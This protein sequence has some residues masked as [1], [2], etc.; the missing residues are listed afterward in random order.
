MKESGYRSI[1]LSKQNGLWDFMD[2][3]D[4]LIVPSDLQDALFNRKNAS[5]FFHSINA[6]SKRF[7]LRYVK[8]AKTEKT[9][10]KRI[11]QIADLSA[12]GEKLKGS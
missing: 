2:D 7:V 12:N 6:S 9:R 11:E 3:V 5:N 10:A 1:E 4:Q 8:L